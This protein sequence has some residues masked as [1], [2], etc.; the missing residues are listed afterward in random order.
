MFRQRRLTFNWLHTSL[1]LRR[2]LHNHGCDN[3]KSYL[4]ARCSESSAHWLFLAWLTLS[5]MKMEARGSSRHWW[6]STG[7][8]GITS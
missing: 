2:K 7:L 8:H 5:T 3:L 1:Y 6:T 4:L